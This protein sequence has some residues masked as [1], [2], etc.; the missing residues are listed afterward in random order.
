MVVQRLNLSNFFCFFFFVTKR[1]GQPEDTINSGKDEV[2]ADRGYAQAV[3]CSDCGEGD[4][5]G[6]GDDCGEGS[7]HTKNVK[8]QV[9]CFN[10][11]PKNFNG[12]GGCG[13]CVDDF[14]KSVHCLC[15]LT[16]FL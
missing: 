1:Y 11:G 9:D 4:A 3:F 12:F 7:T 15:L 10:D 6:N 2:T 8:N 5:S 14:K 16:W 13:Y